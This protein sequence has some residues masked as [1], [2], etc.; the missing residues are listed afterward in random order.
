MQILVL[1]FLGLNATLAHANSPAPNGVW[2]EWQ[3]AKTFYDSGNY[4]EALH[5]LRSHSAESAPYFYNLGTVFFQLKQP[6]SALAYLEKANRIS[7]HDPQ[8]QSNLQLAQA[9]LGRLIGIDRLDPASSAVE[10]MTDR[11]SINEVRGTLGMLGLL[12]ALLWL[13][14]YLRTRKLKEA[15]LQPAGFIALLGFALTGGLY[16]AQRYAHAHPPTYVLEQVFVRSGP[17]DQFVQLSQL[18]AGVKL[19]RMGPEQEG[20]S[21]VRYSQDGIGWVRSSSL[22]LL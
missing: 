14:T 20:W 15:L 16:L 4:D 17:G 22:L 12:V 1:L 5:S 11:V 21:Q 8:I 9:T 13:R 6:G 7:P 3:E 10:S 19:R 18:E 2:A